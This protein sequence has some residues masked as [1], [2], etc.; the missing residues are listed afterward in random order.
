MSDSG[1]ILLIDDE[2]A[3]RHTLARIFQRA[4]FDITTSASGQEGLALLSQQPFDL[5]Y[6]DIRMPD[7][8]GLE[9]HPCKIP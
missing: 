5:V 8:N 9:V 6:L 3:L 7:M 1:H 4:G 2:E